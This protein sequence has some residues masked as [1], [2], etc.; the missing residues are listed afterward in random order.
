MEQP[1]QSGRHSGLD[2]GIQAPGMANLWEPPLSA[3]S[4]NGW[5]PVVRAPLR[6]HSRLVR[7][8]ARPVPDSLPSQQPVSV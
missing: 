5:S 8:F 3:E 6:V 2:A 4:A 1:I 7:A